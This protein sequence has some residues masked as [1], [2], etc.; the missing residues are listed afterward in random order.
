MKIESDPFIR[1]IL[2]DKNLKVSQENRVLLI[3]KGNELLND[4]KVEE[5]KKIFISIKYSDGLVRL[6][7]FY[8]KKNDFMEAARMYIISGN[9]DKIDS[10]SKEIS[11]VIKKWIAL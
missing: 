5:A 4:S 9:R 6:G 3:R 11:A 1:K 2:D 10:I 8:Y 7:D